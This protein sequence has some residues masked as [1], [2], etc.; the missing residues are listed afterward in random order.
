[1]NIL[2]LQNI[3]AELKRVVFEAC[4]ENEID[5]RTPML[6]KNISEEK[7]TLPQYIDRLEDQTQLIT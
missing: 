3:D 7:D 2:Q 1:M 4:K 5:I 6:L